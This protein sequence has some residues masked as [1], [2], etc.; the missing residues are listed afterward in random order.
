MHFLLEGMAV[1]LLKGRHKHTNTHSILLDHHLFLRP[2]LYLSQFQSI[3]TKVDTSREAAWLISFIKHTHSMQLAPKPP[4]LSLSIFISQYTPEH[5]NIIRWPHL[6]L[7][8]C[9]SPSLNKHTRTQE[10][11]PCSCCN[12]QEESNQDTTHFSALCIKHTAVLVHFCASWWNAWL[13]SFLYESRHTQPLWSW[14]PTSF[15]VHFLLSDNSWAYE[16][17]KVDTS[18]AAAWLLS[19]IK[20]TNT[21]HTACS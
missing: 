6:K 9:C 19:F 7:Q 10:H 15:S 5:M 1:F 17:N 18:G 2:Y 13:Y 20:H 16:D 12:E 4:T 8:L 11:I 3:W 21:Q 14:I